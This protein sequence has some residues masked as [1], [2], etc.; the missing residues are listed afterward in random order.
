MSAG[1][2][3]LKVGGGPGGRD[4]LIAPLLKEVAGNEGSWFDSLRQTSTGTCSTA[5]VGLPSDITEIDVELSPIDAQNLI[6]DVAKECRFGL[7]VSCPT[8]KD[9]TLVAVSPEFEAMTGYFSAELVGKGFRHLTQGCDIEPM[10][11]VGMRLAHAT[12]AAFKAQVLNRR[13]TGE[14]FFNLVELRG[15][16][17]GHDADTGEDLW[18]IVGIQ[19]DVTELDERDM[20][21][22]HFQKFQM[23]ADAIR[24]RV[25]RTWLNTNVTVGT[26]ANDTQAWWKHT[27]CYAVGGAAAALAL[28]GVI[29]ACEHGRVRH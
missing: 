28:A 17:V 4:D 15:L 14:K 19:A 5:S 24:S 26:L 11:K 12:G 2:P 8:I 7:T 9:N 22:D 23:F 6:R 18:Y 13:K 10:A 1:R 29:K 27:C 3:M 16:T 20:P 25:E 21:Q